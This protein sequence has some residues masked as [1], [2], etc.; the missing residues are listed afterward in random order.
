VYCAG[1]SATRAFTLV[2]V[3]IVGAGRRR[4]GD[5]AAGLLAARLAGRRLRGMADVLLDLDGWAALEALD[6]RKLLIVVDAAEARGGLPPGG[7]RRM[8]FRAAPEALADCGLRDT[9]TAGVEAVLKLADALG[10]LP[11]SVWVYAIAGDAFRPEE[12]I[13]PA[14]RPTIL[15]VAE[16][17]AADAR[18]WAEQTSGNTNP[19]PGPSA[20]GAD[21]LSG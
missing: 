4:H 3:L 6:G 7:W 5:D 17:I 1:L 2:P 12:R 20:R 11:P 16:R 10:R 13:S 8:D 19:L 14:A 15:T 9:H 21:D 18:R